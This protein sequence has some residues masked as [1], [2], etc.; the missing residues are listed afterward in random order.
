MVMRKSADLPLHGGSAPP[1]LFKR[2][3]RL[4]GLICELIV[5]DYG[6]KELL[7]KLSDPIWFQAFGC[8]LGFDWHSSGL[9]TV[10]CGAIK[11]A[12][13][14][15]S[16][17]IGI[18]I[19]GGKGG[20]SRKTPQEISEIA[21]R[22]ALNFG[23]KLIYASKL[24]AKVDSA[25]LQDGYNLYHHCFLFDGEGNWTVIQ[26]GMNEQNRYARRYHWFAE[27]LD[28]DFVNE[29]HSG[30][31]TSR[32]ME[33]ILNMV[34]RESANAR[35]VIVEFIKDKPDK[36]IDELTGEDILFLPAHHNV[37]LSTRDAHRLRDLM[38]KI[39]QTPPEDFEKLIGFPGVGPST[40][41]ALALIAELVYQTPV[42]S[43]DPA[44]FSFAHGGKDGHPF[45]V[46][47]NLYDR[48]IAILEDVVRKAKISPNDKDHA[49]RR[50]QLWLNLRY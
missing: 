14:K 21:D 10:T 3:T 15:T 35:E 24:S 26:Q 27:A 48:D 22:F 50:L 45:P 46:D 12:Y 39:N 20:T 31:I 17:A 5:I 8:V 9:T 6:P 29:P 41:R 25:C 34:A 28:K 43:T 23:E 30:I 32:R 37:K 44:R 7:K 49:L 11:E 33:D 40:V 36:V 38:M 16:G 47:R 13:R 19:A 1:W 2:M 4:A 42:S 18:H